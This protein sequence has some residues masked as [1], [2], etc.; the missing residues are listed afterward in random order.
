MQIVNSVQELFCID[1]LASVSVELIVARGAAVRSR[2][3]MC[4][5]VPAL[6]PRKTKR[7]YNETCWGTKDVPADTPH[8]SLSPGV[9]EAHCPVPHRHRDMRS[10]TRVMA[11]RLMLR[12]VIA[13]RCHINPVSHP[14]TCVGTPPTHPPSSTAL[15]YGGRCPGSWCPFTCGGP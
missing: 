10:L 9:L 6:R 3:S 5:K 13:V 7:V 8:R 11:A 4:R 1:L 14:T 12:C 2:R 15:L